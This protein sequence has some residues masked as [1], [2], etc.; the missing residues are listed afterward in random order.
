MCAARINELDLM[1][2]SQKYNEQRKLY[3]NMDI[4]YHLHKL[5]YI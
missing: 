2:E 4:Q 3:K 5:K 1:D